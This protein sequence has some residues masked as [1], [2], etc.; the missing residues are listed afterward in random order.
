MRIPVLLLSV[1]LV[2]SVVA[3]SA[4]STPAN[5]EIVTLSNRADLISGGDALVEVRVPQNVP[6]KK[7]TLS[8]NGYDVTA[9]FVTSIQWLRSIAKLATT[10]PSS[11]SR[12]E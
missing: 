4:E 12:N 6:L 9:S 11:Q 8:L 1:S 3:P 7:V 10:R 5:F 2:T